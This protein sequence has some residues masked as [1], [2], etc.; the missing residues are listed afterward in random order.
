MSHFETTNLPC[1]DSAH[2]LKQLDDLA[3]QFEFVWRY[4]RARRFFAG[5]FYASHHRGPRTEHQFATLYSHRLEA[6]EA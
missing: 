6:A 4:L 5:E 2:V 1:L 3:L